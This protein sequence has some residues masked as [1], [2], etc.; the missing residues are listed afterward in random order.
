MVSVY[1]FLCRSSYCLCLLSCVSHIGRKYL[2][3][4]L[5]SKLHTFCWQMNGK[6]A[7][8][9][10]TIPKIG[11]R[12]REGDLFPATSLDEYAE[13]A[14]QSDDEEEDDDIICK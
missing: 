1:K 3:L 4:V 11:D 14:R 12:S 13:T 10:S 6:N 2:F 8:A 7:G 5:Y 9:E